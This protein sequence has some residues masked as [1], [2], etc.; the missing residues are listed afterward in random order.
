METLA[1]IEEVVST[2]QTSSLE[3][4]FNSISIEVSEESLSSINYDYITCEDNKNAVLHDD[5]A[6]IGSALCTIFA[7]SDS[8]GVTVYNKD[9]TRSIIDRIDRVIARQVNTVLKDGNFKEI[10]QQ[11]R[12]IQDLYASIPVASGVELTLFDAS[13][14]ELL[15]DFETNAVDISSSDLFK[16]VYI[17]E[18]DQ[19]GGEPYGSIVGL[20][21]FENTEDDINWLS[22]MGKISAASHAPFISAVSPVFFGC[23]SM[24]Q[25]HEIKDINA[26]MSNHRY[27]K[28]NAFRKSAQAAYIGLTLPRYLVRAPYDPINNSAGKLLPNFVEEIVGP[29]SSDDFVWGNSAILM[30]KNMVRSFH[31]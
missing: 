25:I 5:F 15:D 18:Y 28:W 14:D 17:S 3:S 27:G 4:I 9:L 24:D 29:H 1:V 11:W 16:K 6:R 22:I 26:L 7:N 13:K 19:Y 2:T 21:E 20:Y 23:E 30:A 31:K 12:S 8:E 10:E